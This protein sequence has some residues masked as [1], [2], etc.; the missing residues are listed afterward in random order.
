MKAKPIA[1]DPT[2]KV[3]SRS[4]GF[5]DGNTMVATTSRPSSSKTQRTNPPSSRPR[6]AVPR[7]PNHA[8][9][10]RRPSAAA[11]TNTTNTP[12]ATARFGGRPE[13]ARCEALKLLDRGGELF[14]HRL[15][16]CGE[17]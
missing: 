9:T 2:P 12:S 17:G 7:R 1:T 14:R 6:S 3:A 10:I 16:L 13:E 5:T 11:A 4:A 8:T 15:L